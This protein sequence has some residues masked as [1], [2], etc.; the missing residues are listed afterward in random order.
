MDKLK[1]V[2][3]NKHKNKQRIIDKTNRILE[4][5]ARNSKN[6]PKQKTNTNNKQ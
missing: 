6:K 1:V 2:K 4:T 5:K 3:T